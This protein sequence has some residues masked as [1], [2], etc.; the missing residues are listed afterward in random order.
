MRI[1]FVADARSPIARSW[2]RYWPQRGYE[3]LVVSTAPSE[4]PPGAADFAVIPVALSAL[5][6]RK[7]SGT[8]KVAPPGGARWIGF[9]KRLRHWAGPLT[10]PAAAGRL[11]ELV[12]RWQ[13]DLVHALRIP[14]EG[15]LAAE[16]LRGLDV[17]LLL[18]VWG[19]DFTLHAPANPLMARAT[20][21]AL[22]RADALHA[23]CRRDVR[24]A[25]EWGWPAGRPSIVLPGNGGLDL[26]VFH[27]PS[28]PAAAPVVVNPRGFR[29]YV[30]NDTFFR[31]IP[32]VLDERPETRFLCAA[33]QGEAAAEAWLDRL[34]IRQAVQLLPHMPRPQLAQVFRQAWVTVSPSVHDGTPNSLLESMACGCVPVAGDLESIREWIADGENGRLVDPGDPQALAAAIVQALNDE[35]WRRQAAA[36]NWRMLQERAEYSACMA[37]AEAFYRSLV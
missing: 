16:A 34:H 13:P 31:A 33:M 15:M 17:P 5:G 29:A 6:R 26:D 27:P 23:D 4:P 21:R 32:L 35:T 12:R 37:Q 30:R 14:F 7:R 1:L 10:L 20:R 24:L 2:L 9:R 19:N 36:H 3:M 8:G 28:Q 25:G 22:A 11:R 18:S